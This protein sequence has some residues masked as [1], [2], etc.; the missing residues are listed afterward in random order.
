MALGV[1]NVMGLILGGGSGV[2]LGG[3]SDI[4][5]GVKGGKF[6]PGMLWVVIHVG[7]GFST[8]W[9]IL[10]R[11][12]I[13]TLTVD[14]DAIGGMSTL[15]YVECWPGFKLVRPTRAEGWGGGGLEGPM[16]G[17]VVESGR[18]VATACL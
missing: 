7:T 15:T 9:L 5:Q 8:G 12:G 2:D 14:N 17:W 18:Q 6:F 1:G 10:V 4:R 11:V 13:S 16:E 3:G